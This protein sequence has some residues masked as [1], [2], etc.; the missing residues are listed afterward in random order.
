MADSN[1]AGGAVTAEVFKTGAQVH[2][3]GHLGSA[4]KMVPVMCMGVQGPEKEL[5]VQWTE[6]SSEQAHLPQPGLAV[7]FYTVATGVMYIARGQ[8][9]NLSDGR[10]PRIRNK[11]DA[12]C[13]AVPLRQSPRYL[14]QGQV[15]IGEP[16]DN[17]AYRQNQPHAMDISLGGFGIQVH[18]RGWLAGQETGFQ[19]KIWVDRGGQ[20]DPAMPELQL[21]GRITIRAVRP[22]DS[23][24]LVNLGAEIT[25]LSRSQLN[26]L[27]MW[28]AAHEIYLREI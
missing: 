19:L 20:P 8:V 1:K 18:N 22:S 17:T 12:V 4:E 13:L 14:V 26:T 7:Q 11:I 10:L 27:Q 9:V 23:P 25:E 21:H 28:L 16:G 2:L 3:R 15:R 24:Q 6:D 5:V